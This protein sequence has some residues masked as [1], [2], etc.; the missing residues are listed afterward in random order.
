[1]VKGL[2]I[3]LAAIP[4]QETIPDS[5]SHNLG[6]NA[7]LLEQINIMLTQNIIEPAMPSS[8]SFVSHMF[9]RPKADGSYRPILN[10]SGLNEFTIYRH[11]K[12][13]H[14]S[15]VMRMV[16]QNSYMAS[17]DI[18]SAYFSLPVKNRDR[19]LLQLQFHGKRYR[20]TC[21]PNGYSPESSLKS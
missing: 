9:L 19:D 7:L 10:L 1:M 15:S 4:T 16:P 8:R 12:M 13:D 11:F 14:L 2:T 6:L 18:T 5:A 21:L 17:I 20:Y 3:E